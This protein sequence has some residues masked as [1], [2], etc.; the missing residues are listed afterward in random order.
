MVDR[1]IVI[2]HSGLQASVVFST[3]TASSRLC[4]VRGS[5]SRGSGGVAQLEGEGPGVMKVVIARWLE[6]RSGQRHSDQ[7]SQV[8]VAAP[9]QQHDVDA[10]WISLSRRTAEVQVTGAC[11]QL[12][13]R[14]PCTLVQASGSG[15]SGA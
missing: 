6:T 2:V 1:N 4:E 7:V 11:R 15:F 8:M 14:F 5:R 10:D 9:A 13:A 3:R 12:D